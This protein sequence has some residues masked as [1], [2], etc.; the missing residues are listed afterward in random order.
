MAA[1]SYF[2]FGFGFEHLLGQNHGS[3]HSQLM[4]GFVMR[5]EC[6]E[7]LLEQGEGS[8]IQICLVRDLGETER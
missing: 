7:V 1:G 5:I 6:S 2:A 4:L 8:P 3:G